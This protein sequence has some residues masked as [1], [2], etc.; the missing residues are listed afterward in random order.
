MPRQADWK[1]PGDEGGARQRLAKELVANVRRIG[2]HQ[3]DVEPIR[4]GRI[5]WTAG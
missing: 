1:R 3:G 5:F 2:P 4:F